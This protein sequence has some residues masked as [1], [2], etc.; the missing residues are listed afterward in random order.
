MAPLR[1][2][3]RRVG[4]RGDIRAEGFDVSRQFDKAL[5]RGT[6]QLRSLSGP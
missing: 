4:A 1:V 6:L 5:I 2:A 3:R